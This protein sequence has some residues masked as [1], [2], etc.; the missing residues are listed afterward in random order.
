MSSLS[1]AIDDCLDDMKKMVERNQLTQEEYDTWMG[2]RRNA[3][4]YEYNELDE[5]WKYC[6]IGCVGSAVMLGLGIGRITHFFSIFENAF[7][8]LICGV[9]FVGIL[10]VAWGVVEFVLARVVAEVLFFVEASV[11][12]TFCVVGAVVR[13]STADQEWVI[14]WLSLG[15]GGLVLIWRTR[16]LIDRHQRLR[17]LWEALPKQAPRSVQ[18]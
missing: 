2:R 10:I 7:G 12:M 11:F 4:I 5:L 3:Q 13:P 1:D 9:L 8:G 14:L 16:E 17:L 15:V 18:K 6:C